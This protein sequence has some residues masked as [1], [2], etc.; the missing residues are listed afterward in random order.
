MYNKKMKIAAFILTAIGLTGCGHSNDSFV[1]KEQVCLNDAVGSDFNIV[2]TDTS[3]KSMVRECGLF[4]FSLT[5]TYYDM[6]KK[7]VFKLK[8]HRQT[9]DQVPHIPY[10]KLPNREKTKFDKIEEALGKCGL[11]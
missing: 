9:N 10:E 5:E 1:S 3:G 7:S 8:D 6:A 11:D 2:S 4:S